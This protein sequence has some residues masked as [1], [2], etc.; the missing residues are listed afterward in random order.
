MQQAAKLVNCVHKCKRFL[1]PGIISSSVIPRLNR[2]FTKMSVPTID[3]TGGLKMPMLGYG[4][5]QAKDEELEQAVEAALEAGYRHIDTAHVYENEKV[6]GKVLSRWFSSG[7]LNRG[8]IFLVTKLPPGGNR[9]ESVQKYIKRSLEFLQVD[10]V[11]LYLVHVP[12]GFKDIEGDLHPVTPEGLINMDTTTDHVALWKAMEAQV[13]AG[14]TKS[15][16]IS[17]FNQKQI[18][19][20][21]QNARIPPSNLQIEL[22]AYLQQKD[23][24]EF[25]KKNKI[26]VT[27]YSPLGSPGL[28][29]FMAQFGTKIDLPDIL[30][31][32]VVRTIAAKHK[33]S[34]AQIVLRHAIQKEIVVIPKSTNPERLRQNIDI[35][36]FQLD[37]QDME[38]LN[39][40]DQGIRI[41]NF[42]VFKGIENHPEFPF[43]Q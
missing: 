43:R 3:L 6:I 23:L 4:T 22:H 33:K 32:P 30:N 9:P 34:E 13:D 18:D 14:L 29:K 28:A 36:N 5:W 42:N 35:F 16:G 20:I 37:E 39:G 26:V 17:N 7:K 25:C 2:N 15:I 11:D 19:R 8:D 41:L 12:F 27:A 31:N 21:L 40:L 38:Q 10:Y 1:T 24:V